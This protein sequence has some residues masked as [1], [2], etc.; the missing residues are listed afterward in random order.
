MTQN[1]YKEKCDELPA[2]S[3]EGRPSISLSHR[4]ILARGI[5]IFNNSASTA[6]AS[7][8]GQ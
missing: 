2:S 8:D 1:L 4:D 7:Q 5:P 6:N 3:T